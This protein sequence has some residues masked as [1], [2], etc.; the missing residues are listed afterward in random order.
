[1]PLEEFAAQPFA[2]KSGLFKR[3]VELCLA[4]IDENYAGFSAIP[5][6]SKEE[7]PSLYLNARD[8]NQSG[9]TAI[10]HEAATS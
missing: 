7:S 9:P 2:Q 1:M 3:I 5:L 10:N 8:L 6:S 4:K